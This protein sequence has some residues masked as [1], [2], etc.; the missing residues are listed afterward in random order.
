M[1]GVLKASPPHPRAP[2]AQPATQQLRVIDA[3]YRP[4]PEIVHMH[5][6]PEKRAPQAVS[7][8]FTVAAV[9]PM[10]VFV[11]LALRSGANLKVGQCLSRSLPVRC[12]SAS[13]GA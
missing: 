3:M 4:K 12:G 8:L 1:G 11:Q 13:T 10:F 5:R 6:K 9:A 2:D 7:L